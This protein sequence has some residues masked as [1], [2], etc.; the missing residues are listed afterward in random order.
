MKIS[1][2]HPHAKVERSQVER[3][4]TGAS[5]E[6]GAAAASTGAAAE[7]RMSETARALTD[8]HGPERPDPARVERLRRAIERGELRVDV[9]RIA[10]AILEQER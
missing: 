7:V 1:G 10:D 8:A 9:G 4:D 6:R 2:H 3:R 5:G